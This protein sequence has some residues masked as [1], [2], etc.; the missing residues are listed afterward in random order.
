MI[1]TSSLYETCQELF[2]NYPLATRAA[3][4]SGT[5][6]LM[7]LLVPDPNSV[8]F[9]VLSRDCREAKPLYYLR[10]W[11]AEG[12][13]KIEANGPSVSDVTVS[14]VTRGVPIPQDEFLFGWRDGRD[15]TALVVF[16]T[17][18]TPE[19]PEPSWA[20]MPL[21]GI[22]ETKWP[23]FTR[24]SVLGHWFWDHYRA[25]NVVSIDEIVAKNPDTVFWVDTQESLASNC[26]AVTRDITSPNGYRLGRGRY[27]YHEV[28]QAGRPAP[29]LSVLLANSNKAD[30]AP[31]FSRSP[32]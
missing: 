31:Q 26:C 3:N 32:Q 7:V 27:I 25:G 18:Y 1:C 20:V 23:P 17:R 22:P 8:R 9:F 14:A 2:T 11:R 6:S 21:V 19:C 12:T 16:Y 24:Q 28:L 10:P 30:L 13:V 29:S 15:I 5:I 4:T